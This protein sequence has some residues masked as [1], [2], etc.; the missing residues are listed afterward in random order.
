MWASL[1]GQSPSVHDEDEIIGYEL[2]GSS[3]V[4]QGDYKLVINPVPKG[5]GEWQLYN[6]VEDPS[7]M[8]DLAAEMPEL[9]ETLKQGY[10]VYE[11]ENGVVRPPEGYNPIEQLV[12]NSK[13][14]DAH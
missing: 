6:I 5:N 12:K 3:A 9:V 7:E 4:Y 10:E 13:R 8:H 1:T 14:K 11:Q 2:G